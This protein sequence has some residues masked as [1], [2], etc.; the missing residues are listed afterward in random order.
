MVEAVVSLPAMTM[1]NR[2]ERMSLSLRSGCRHTSASIRQHTSG[3]SRATRSRCSA[4]ALSLLFCLLFIRAMPA[5][6]QVSYPG[7]PLQ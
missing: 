1:S 7:A 4:E 6:V 5:I 3:N 2:I